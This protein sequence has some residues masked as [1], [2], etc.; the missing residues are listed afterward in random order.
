MWT[1]GQLLWVEGK[2]FSDGIDNADGKTFSRF[3][4][5]KGL[6][7][8]IEALG[9]VRVSERSYD[10]DF[11]TANEKALDD[12][13]QEFDDL[14]DAYWYDKDVDTYAIRRADGVVW[15]V[16]QTRNDDAAVLVAEGPAP[17]LD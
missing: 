10:R 17:A 8:Q 9:G 1:G 5:A 4:L 3:E 6:R 15:V 7:Q 11:Y 16:L 13:R 12:F 14:Q 2:V